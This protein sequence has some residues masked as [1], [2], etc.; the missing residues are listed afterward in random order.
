MH[1]KICAITAMLTAPPHIY[2]LSHL[3][4]SFFVKCLFL[5]LKADINNHTYTKV[6]KYTIKADNVCTFWFSSLLFI[7]IFDLQCFDFMTECL[8]SV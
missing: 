8:K 2:L 1:S 3:P 6:Y 4:I 7:S 5:P